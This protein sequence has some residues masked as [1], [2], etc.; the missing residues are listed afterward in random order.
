MFSGIGACSGNPPDICAADDQADD[1]LPLLG[2]RKRSEANVTHRLPLEVRRSAPAK[3]RLCAKQD[4]QGARPP[5]GASAQWSRRAAVG[6]PRVRVN[7]N[8]TSSLA[9]RILD[10]RQC[11][12]SLMVNEICASASKFTLVSEPKLIGVMELPQFKVDRGV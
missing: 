3:P 8:S 7:V 5:A 10:G 2:F 12:T 6:E 11:P 9:R 4:R 1:L